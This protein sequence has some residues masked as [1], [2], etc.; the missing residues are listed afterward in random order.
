MGAKLGPWAEIDDVSPEDIKRLTTASF[1]IESE[2]KECFKAVFNTPA[3]QKCLDLLHRRYVDQPRFDP[4][5]EHPIFAAFQAEGAAKLVR[6]IEASLR[7][8]EGE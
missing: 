1:T 2:E 3:G 4:T 6:M 8:Y 5:V 7:Q